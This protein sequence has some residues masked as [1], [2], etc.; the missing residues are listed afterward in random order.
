MQLSLV[1]IIAIIFINLCVVAYVVRQ[2]DRSRSG[3]FLFMNALSLIMWSFGK[4]LAGAM[5]SASLWFN[6]LPCLAAMIIPGNMLYY[7]L[8]RPRTMGAFWAKPAAGFLIFAPGMIIVM[9][10]DYASGGPMLF[11]YSFWSDTIP[12]DGPMRRAAM[13]YCI[14]LLFTSVLVLG[15]RYYN[16]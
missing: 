13:L 2:S 12:L 9:L 4:I 14:V 16:S 3:F 11:D 5:P 6:A 10:Q 15:I 8:T 1:P 7:A